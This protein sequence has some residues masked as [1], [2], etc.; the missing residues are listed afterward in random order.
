MAISS[1]RFG[2]IEIDGKQYTKDLK[3][4]DGKVIENWWRKEG[5]LCTINDIKDI[6]EATPHTLILGTG[7]SGLMKP[8]LGLSEKLGE[9]GIRLECIP[10]E[11]AVMRYNELCDM[12]GEDKVAFAAHLTC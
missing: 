5:H 8:A 9:H 4:I 2:N 10:T 3:I 11:L 12:V 6:I 7:A 1:Y